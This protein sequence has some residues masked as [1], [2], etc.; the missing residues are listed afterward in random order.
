MNAERNKEYGIALLRISLGVMFIAHSVLLKYF[1]FTLAGTAGYFESI[2]LPGFLAYV[3]FGMEAGAQHHYKK[4]ARELSQD[5]AARL[6]GILPD[7]VDRKVT[8]SAASERARWIHA[9]PAPFPG[10]KHY[11]LVLDKWEST[12]KDDRGVVHV[13]T[14][15]YNQDG[16]VVCTFR[17]K[18][19]VPK[20]N[21]LDA[22]GG[23]Q[24]GRPVPQPD[25]FWP[26][27]PQPDQA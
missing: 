20:Q 21:Y 16:K 26:G 14:I 2:G 4:H 27:H 18:V 23:E 8:G 25:K 3:V 13:E 22:R 1:T 6:A 15:G 17:R 7:P 11:D 19:M 5:Q 24:P 12:S 10:D 9:N